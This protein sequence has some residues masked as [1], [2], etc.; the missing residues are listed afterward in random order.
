MR[1]DTSEAR[2][3]ER[4]Q[5][6][7]LVGAERLSRTTN[8]CYAPDASLKTERSALTARQ[9]TTARG[10][11]RGRVD[12]RAAI[13]SKRWCFSIG[14]TRRAM[15]HWQVGRDVLRDRKSTEDSCFNFGSSRSM[16]MADRDLER[17]ITQIEDIEAIRKLKARFC[18]YIDQRSRWRSES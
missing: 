8:S 13:G 9:L 18:L 3:P 1:V 17:R 5:E 14:N 7:S 12:A 11:D 4:V 10:E 16:K 15:S 6:G 2:Q